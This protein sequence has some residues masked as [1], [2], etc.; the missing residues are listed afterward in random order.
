MRSFVLLLALV[1]A[2]FASPYYSHHTPL[3]TRAGCPPEGYVALDARFRLDNLPAYRKYAICSPL[4]DDE[5]VVNKGVFK[6]SHSQL[7]VDSNVEI[8]VEYPGRIDFNDVFVDQIDSTFG[9]ISLYGAPEDLHPTPHNDYLMSPRFGN[10]GS[11]VNVRIEGTDEAL[12]LTNCSGATTLKSIRIFEEGVTVR[13]SSRLV[14]QDLVVINDAID[15]VHSQAAFIN[16]T[17]FRNTG[18]DAFDVTDGSRVTIC[19]GFIE[20]GF[21]LGDNDG[22][23]VSVAVAGKTNADFSD[24]DYDGQGGVLFT[25]AKCP[26]PLSA[27]YDSRLWTS[28]YPGN[29]GNTPVDR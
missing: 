29:G 19:D 26:A 14:F 9:G 8:K 22:A 20:G 5:F 15:V 16:P 25:L 17:V 11:L 28:S 6:L 23:T 2:C 7:V 10:C 12:S 4:D 18:S 13:D 1:G 3:E 27:S 21:Q 24:I